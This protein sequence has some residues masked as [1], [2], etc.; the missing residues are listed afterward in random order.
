MI[1]TL[2]P[3]LFTKSAAVMAMMAALAP[4]MAGTLVIHNVSMATE[5][6]LLASRD[7]GFLLSSYIFNTA[8]VIVVLK[9]AEAAVG[10]N[11]MVVWFCILQFQAVRLLQNGLRLMSRKSCLNE[12][13]ALPASA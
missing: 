3:T 4:I 1:V 6:M 8:M 13:M 5:G 10:R 7:L 11:I 9:V 2:A 12:V